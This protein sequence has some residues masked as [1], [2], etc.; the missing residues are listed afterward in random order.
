[1]WIKRSP[2]VNLLVQTQRVTSLFKTIN[3]LFSLVVLL[4]INAGCAPKQRPSPPENLSLQVAATNKP[5]VYA[6]SGKANFPEQSHITVLAIRYLQPASSRAQRWRSRPYYAILDRQIVTLNQGQWQTQLNLWKAAPD[7]RWQE[8]WQLNEDDAE[9][10]AQPNK[11]VAFLALLQP[12]NQEKKLRE[13]LQ[14]QG[15]PLSQN[16][17]PVPSEGTWYIYATQRLEVALPSG[18]TQPPGIAVEDI[19]HGWGDRNAT[20]P[21]KA[22][23]SKD[24]TPPPPPPKENLTDLPLSQRDYMR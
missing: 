13:K 9:L 22:A 19:N 15:P 7:G 12:D 18:K 5:G 10:S 16:T 21:Q 4:T 11:Q 17:A 2:H 20:K 23:N 1:M 3:G 24:A 14:T 8:S 6:I